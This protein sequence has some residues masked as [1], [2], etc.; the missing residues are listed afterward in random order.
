M[1]LIKEPPV[2]KR[3]IQHTYRKGTPEELERYQRLREQIEQEKPEMNTRAQEALENAIKT[4]LRPR[5]A[6]H[7]LRRERQRQGLSLADLKARSGIDRASACRL[8]N[9]PDANPT[10]KTLE[11]Y[12][13]AVGKKLLIV[14]LDDEQEDLGKG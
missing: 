14:L 5:T 3:P 1:H 8:E 10:I 13:S 4:G 11:R 9:D 7:A 12:A 2:E 6:I